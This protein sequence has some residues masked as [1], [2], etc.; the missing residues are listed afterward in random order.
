MKVNLPVD[1]GLETLDYGE[2]D[3]I[4]LAETKK[5]EL[6]LIDERKGFDEAQRRNIPALRTVFLLERAARGGL[7]DLADAFGKLRQTNFRVSP[8]LLDDILTEHL[9]R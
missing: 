6:L 1:A 5:A 4:F 9:S 3:A 2:R 8:L 7:I